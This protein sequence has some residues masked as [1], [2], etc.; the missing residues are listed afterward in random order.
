M[1]VNAETPP[2]TGHHTPA[3]ER[4]R[5]GPM[6]GCLRLLTGGVIVLLL[7]LIILTAG[8]WIYLGSPNF[9]DFVRTKIETTLSTRLGR[10]VTIGSIKIDRVHFGRAVLND[11]RIANAPGGVHPYFATARQVVIVGGIQSFWGRDISVGSIQVFDPRMYIEIYPAGS[12]LVHNF[13]HWQAPPPSRFQIVHVALN[14]VQIQNGV[15]DFLDRRHDLEATASGVASTI[16]VTSSKNLY[17]GVMNSPQ[18]RVRLQDYLP[19][20]MSMRGLFRYTP[21]TIDLPSIALDGGPDLRLFV[22][23]RIAPLSQGAYDLHLASVVGLPRIRQIFRIQKNLEGSVEMDTTLR[24]QQGAFVLSG[25]WISPK[26]RADIY[27][28]SSLRGTLRVDGTHTVVDVQRGSFSGGTLTAHY[29]L[30]GYAEPY[31]MSVD[32]HYDGISVEQLFGHWGLANNG[33][34]AGASGRLLYHWNKDNIL[35]GAG[36]GAATLSK[37]SAGPSKAKYPVPIGGSADFALNNG[38]ITFRRTDLATD[39]TRLGLTGTLRIA[40]LSADFL[41]KIHSS[42]F[43]ELDRIGYD[44]AHTLGKKTFTLLGLGGD[45]DITGNVRGLLKSPEVVAHV[46]ATGTKY[47]DSLLGDSDIDL[48]YSGR[49]DLVTL[50]HAVF[51]LAGGTLTLTG[52]IG[53]PAKGPSPRFDLAVD[54]VNYP[55]ERA[56]GR[57][58]FKVAIRGAGSGKLTV[59]ATRDGG[60]VH[61]TTLTITQATGHLQL[62]GLIAWKPGVGNVDFDLNVSAQSFPVAE[63]V[64]FLDLG[65]LPISGELTGTLSLRGPKNAL[66]GAGQVTVRNGSIYGEPVTQAAAKIEFTK[67]AI[68]ATNVVVTAPAGTLT[69]EAAL[70][71]TTNQFSYNVQSTGI[72]VS[73]LNILSSLNGLFGGTLVISS[74]GAGT[75]QQPQIVFTATLNQATVRG[76]NLPAGASAPTLYFAIR[77]GQLIVRGSA[78]DALTIE[79]NGSMATDG[80]LAGAV[81]I[82]IPDLAKLVAMF[83]STA[84]I[85][86]SGSI[87]ANLQLGGKLTPLTA[88]RIDATFPQ[89]TVQISEDRLTPLRPLRIGV[90]DGRIVFD[91]FALELAK[92]GQAPSNFVITGYADLTGAKLVNIDVS[93]TLEAALLEAFIPGARAEG[94]INLTAAGIH[95]TLSNPVLNGTADFQNAQ[96]R[97]PGFPQLIDNITGTLLF[98]GDRV[99]IDSLR[100]TV[101]G[102]TIV[103]G[104]SIGLNGISPVRL[105][106]TLQG[107]GV[108]IRYYEGTSVEGNFLLTL[109]GDS[110]RMILQGDVH[111]TRAVYFKD[112]DIGNAILGVLLSRRAVTPV[113]AASWQD[114]VSLRVHL[115]AP[116]STLAVH[117]NIANVT[118]SGELDVTGTVANPSVLGTVTLDEGGKVRFQNID[119]QVVRGSINFQNPF[120]IDPYF[121]ITLQA[122]VSGGISELESGP[123]DVTLNIT[124]TLD[125]ITPTITSEPPASDITLFSLLGFAGVAG[126]V[127]SPPGSTTQSAQRS[128]LSQSINLLGQRILPFVDSFTYDPGVIDPTGRPTVAFEKRLSNDVT[129]YVEHGLRDQKNRV[130]VEWAVN[131]EWV[132]QFTRDEVT[133]TYQAE[134]RFRRT[135]EGHWTWGRRGRNGA[136]FARFVNLPLPKISPPRVPEVVPPPPGSPNVTSVG[137]TADSQFDTSVL[138]KYVTVRAGTPL[139]IRDVQSSIKSLYATG[140]FRDIRVTSTPSSGGV[141]LTFALFINYRVGEIH[142]E[143]LE[144]S[145]RDHAMRELTFHVGD[146]FSLDAVDR[147]ATAIQDLLHRSGYLEP[148]VDEETSFT[149]ALSSAS[150]TFTVHRGPRATV[151]SV[152]IEGDIA[153]FTTET[154]VAQMR[155]GPKKPFDL[156]SARSD[157][158]RMKGF[159]IRRDYRKADVRF[160]AYTYDSTAKTVALR[161]RATAG[162]IVRVV[163]TGV[164]AHAVRGLVPFRK[165]EGYSEDV[166]DKASQD[167]IDNY[168]LHGYFNAAVDTEEHLTGNVWT[169]T[170][171]VNPGVRYHLAAVTFSGNAKLSAKKLAGVITTS[172]S[173][174][175]RSFFQKL[176]RRPTGGTRAQLS[177]DRDAIESLYRLNGFPEVQVSTPVVNTNNATGAMTVNFPIV[178]GP[179]TIVTAVNVEGNQQVPATRLPALLIKPGRPLNPQDERED[180]IDLQSFYANRGNA[181]VQ[182][183]PREQISDDKTKATVTYTIAEGPK[184]DV[185]QVIVRG[186]TYTK[187]NVIL[188][189]AQI[190]SGDPF[191]Y[192]SILDAQRNLYRLGIFNRV[193]IEPEQTGTSV[194]TRNIDISVEEGKDLTFAASGGLTSGITTTSNQIAPL[195]SVSVSNRNLFGTGRYI[196]LQLIGALGPVPRRD[197]FLTYKEPFI[198]PWD[199]PVQLTIFQSN[200]PRLTAQLRQRGLFVEA[201]KVLGSDTRVSLRYEY[202]LADCVIQH[203]NDTD[204]CYEATQALIPGV[205]RSITNIKIADVTPTF[206][207]DRRDDPINPHRGF[208]TS[209]SLEYAFRVFAADAS[210]VKEFGQASWYF[211]LT[212]RTT[213]AVSSRLGLI[214][215]LGR[216]FG[217]SGSVTSGVPLSER[218]TAGGDSS[219]RAYALDLLGTIC[220]NPLDTGCRPTLIRLQNGTI[221][222]IGGLGLFLANAEYRFPMVGNVGGALFVDAGNV[223]ADSTIHLSDLRYGIGTGVRYLSPVG[224]LRFDVGYKL[225]RQIIGYDPS[226]RAIYEKP[227]AYFVSIGYAF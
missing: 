183:K 202:R 218:F 173:G 157:A 43:S 135:Y 25:G 138:Q 137:F 129:V 50:T 44:F 133:Q 215:D 97:I 209:A 191:S 17:A 11:I 86:A 48:R 152:A 190:D 82:R 42:D 49:R 149:R 192:T 194:S 87:A 208:F 24:G 95:G 109:S 73:K 156:G 101:G 151:G 110:N 37:A 20:D 70:N 193:D 210:F 102:G 19:F 15:V 13:P 60:R 91:D 26:I 223:F 154:L 77:D 112:I 185:G 130:V 69:G 80:T 5:K 222:P 103:A 94:H 213:F 188:R 96:L 198:G 8:I 181:E 68:R 206:F 153:P 142:I 22:N 100:A 200:E 29:V 4:Q 66:E 146:V 58:N 40:D 195:G 204:L 71:L 53:F 160:L 128:L 125:R 107:T 170:F 169:I 75:F 54:A 34:R 46:T 14:K 177:A 104:G 225:K 62:A 164:S 76:L 180:V 81:Q 106:V 126:T 117:D 92:A 165:N 178:E 36:E 216:T 63:I 140:D 9:D 212:Q 179:Q 98:R 155:R 2:P 227:L 28:M 182:V 52:T 131:S 168:Q 176:F 39:V 134:A 79:G 220:L 57:A 72:N 89:F 211:P 33:L 83:P 144:R 120:R 41:M 197:A 201:S 161:Y 172:V 141:A 203:Y 159:M 139:S 21:D 148:T 115:T 167:I 38:V 221:A 85:P 136:S 127:A 123:V 99:D 64:K 7:A 121:D 196:G 219:N 78:A 90:R 147:G 122:R 226:G 51:R 163:V 214:Q 116:Q 30:P 143:G 150:V 145:D 184:I 166:V 18:V 45:G 84:G 113:V 132:L 23:G 114:R 186:N 199:I 1:D 88:L 205:D 31:P 12:P 16:D 118:G 67:G 171:H 59:R 10:T 3:R 65:T 175:I 35:N 187:T 74:T 158:D 105:R 61:F 6:W 162:P 108:T 55:V 207:W 56:M 27:E 217:P 93:G 119:Y 189:Q 124:G 32:V 224:P 174:G 111:V 47:N